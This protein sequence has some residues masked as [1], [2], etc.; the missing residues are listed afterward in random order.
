MDY[1]KF[2]IDDSIDYN[3]GNIWCGLKFNK[4]LMK[5]KDDF[6]E[7]FCQQ[8]EY[9]GEFYFLKTNIDKAKEYLM[10]ILVSDFLRE[11]ENNKIEIKN[12]KEKVEELENEISRIKDE[13]KLI[14][15]K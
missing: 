4:N 2:Y 10:H 7:N 14:S 9:S 1:I 11:E 3:D 5:E 12:L 13:Y 15:K 6:I 8:S